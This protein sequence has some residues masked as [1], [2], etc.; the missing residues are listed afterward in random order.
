[1]IERRY[2]RSMHPEPLPEG[3]THGESE[4]IENTGSGT[5]RAAIFG[6]SDG[7]VSNLALVMGVAGGTGQNGEAV[8][9]AGTVGLLA[10][11]F[12]MAAGE[13]IS[14]KTQ[15]ESMEK[16]LQLEREHILAFPKEEQA[17]LGH[18]LVESG[19]SQEDAEDIAHKVHLN[20]DPAVGFHALLELGIVP[21]QMG[22]PVAAAIASFLSFVV[23]ALIPL[24]PWLILPSALGESIV[25]SAIALMAVGGAV[26]T[27]TRRSAWWG[28]LRQLAFGGA[29][30]AITWQLGRLV[31]TAF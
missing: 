4:H 19:L 7:L 3:Y 16:Q 29:A 25:V 13:Y 22:S 6:V 2:S 1:M 12:S 10:G 27:V 9:V 26:T 21:D 11:A 30:A 17:H 20:I 14:M 23:G 18:L 8:V 24:L 5:L 15:R 28:A 31:G